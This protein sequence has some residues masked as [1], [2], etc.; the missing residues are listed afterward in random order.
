MERERESLSLNYKGSFI[1]L[2]CKVHFY[3]PASESC[4]IPLE[5]LVQILPTLEKKNKE[6]CSNTMHLL[7][8]V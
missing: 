7:C 3:K 2:F 1:L 6:A 5:L 8:T 4:H